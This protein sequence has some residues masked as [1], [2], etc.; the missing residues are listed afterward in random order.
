MSAVRK[1]VPLAD[2]VLVRRVLAKTQTAGGIYL[3]DSAT[4]KK[5]PE[6]EIIAVGPGGRT[7]DGDLIPMTLAIGDKVLLPEYGSCDSAALP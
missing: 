3:P 4:S 1:L 5:E 7:K 2:R 6:G